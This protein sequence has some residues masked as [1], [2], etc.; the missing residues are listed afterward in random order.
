ME[1]HWVKPGTNNILVC[2]TSKSTDL[3]MNIVSAKLLYIALFLSF[4]KW[5]PLV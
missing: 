1:S 4:L 3:S 2:F 5:H